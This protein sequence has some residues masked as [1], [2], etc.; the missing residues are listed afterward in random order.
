MHD[1]IFFRTTFLNRL[2]SQPY[3][4]NPVEIPPQEVEVKG[5]FRP[6]NI[7][8]Q[9]NCG[10][11][12]ILLNRPSALNALDLGMIQD[13]HDTYKEAEG[14]ESVFLYLL[15]GAGDKAFCA[16]GATPARPPPHA[17]GRD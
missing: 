2:L 3:F 4:P 15:Y 1:V 16:G 6:S 12:F 11:K 8:V 9:H 13:L 7:F 10:S 17:A 5:L 14:D